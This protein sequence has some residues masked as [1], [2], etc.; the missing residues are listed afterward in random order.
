MTR[1]TQRVVPLRP[2]PRNFTAS[3]QVIEHLS[4]RIMAD[5]HKY[6]DI[7]KK[8]GVAGTTIGNLARRKTAWPRPHTFFAVL[9]YFQIKLKLDE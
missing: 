6:S 3:E 9:N 1:A 4:Q 2:R 7:A 5:G 8:C